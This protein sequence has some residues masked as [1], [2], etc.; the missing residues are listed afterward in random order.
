MRK[1]KWLLMG[2]IGP[3]LSRAWDG[4]KKESDSLFKKFSKDG[5]TQADFDALIQRIEWED[6]SEHQLEN[7][8]FKLLRS[9]LVGGEPS[10]AFDLLNHWINR[11]SEDS[12]S[13]TCQEVISKIQAVGLYL[14]Q[15][16]AHHEEWFS[17]IKPI[18]DESIKSVDQKA[19]ESDFYEGV[20]V[21]YRHILCG[22]DV[23]RTKKL[24]AI[25]E[26]YQDGKQVVVVHGASGQ[27][28]SALAYRYLH[29]YVPSDWRFSIGYVEDRK[30]AANIALAISDHHDAFEAPVYVYIDVR[31]SDMEWP[32]LIKLL[33]R[34][35]NI[36]VL[37]TIREEDLARASV[38][39][40][41]LGFPHFIDLVL[42]ESEA[43]LI[44]ENL[45]KR[46]ASH[47]YPSFAEAW[48]HFG[49]QGPLLE[50]VFL[51]TQTETL[52]ERVRNQVSRL[53]EEVRRGE[54]SPEELDLLRVCS[55]AT[56]Y[57]AQVA[58]KDVCQLIHLN[59]PSATLR[60]FEQEYLLRLSSDGHR[61]VNLHPLRSE[62]LAQEL[63]DE[64]F[65][66]WVDAAEVALKVI[67]D[68]CLEGFLLYAFSRHPEQAQQL[69]EK[70]LNSPPQSWVGLIG[71]ARTF[72]WLGIKDY[73][74]ENIH[75]I[76]DAQ[77]LFG[78]GWFMV[79]NFDLTGQID[80]AGGVDD[81]FK[82]VNPELAKMCQSLRDQQTPRDR[83]FLHLRRWLASCQS[84]AEPMI[85][86]DWRAL[87]ELTSWFQFLGVQNTPFIRFLANLNL[88]WPNT[89]LSLRHLCEL[90]NSLKQLSGSISKPLVEP[91]WEEVLER[92]K[93]ELLVI[94]L[95]SDE[96]NIKAHYVIDEELLS[97]QASEHSLH[98]G[99]ME[100]VELLALLFPEYETYGAQGYGH[101]TRLV[102]T[103]Y[104]PTRKDRIEAS[105]LRPMWLS[106]VNPTFLSLVEWDL[107]PMTWVEYA[108]NSLEIRTEI[109]S[110]LK[111]LE[112]ALIAYFKKRRT[113]NLG[114]RIDTQRWDNAQKMSQN[115][116]LLPQLA[117]D[118]WGLV[119]ETKTMA[120]NQNGAIGGQPT[121]VVA[122]MIIESYRKLVKPVSGYFSACQNFLS[123]AL[124]PILFNSLTARTTAPEQLE[125]LLAE[126]EK[127]NVTNKHSHL[128]AI[129]LADARKELASYQF[130]FRKTVGVINSKAKLESLELKESK[131][132]E[133]LCPLW[134]QFVYSPETTFKHPGAK[135]RIKFKNILS[136]LKG[137]IDAA[138]DSM[139]SNAYCKFI[140][141]EMMYQGEKALWVGLDVSEH[142]ELLEEPDLVRSLFGSAFSQVQF[143]S[144]EYH[145][146]SFLFEHVIVVPHIRNYTFSSNALCIPL[147][148]LV[149]KEE[150]EL[151]NALLYARELEA[152]TIKALG[153]DIITSP[154]LKFIESM[155]KS[156]GKLYIL[157]E[158]LACLS[159][160]PEDVGEDGL[161]IFKEYCSH[162][163]LKIQELIDG[164]G[165]IIESSNVVSYCEKKKN[166]DISDA[167]SFVC[168]VVQS[169]MPES[170]DENAFT[171]DQQGL[172][173]WAGELAESTAKIGIAQWYALRGEVDSNMR[174]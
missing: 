35:Q 40:Y 81:L 10:S 146:L 67:A 74:S 111:G 135:C 121:P 150:E 27:G 132:F 159:N 145:V 127:H 7:N 36:R 84:F 17:S 44:F 109:F 149:G 162:K 76:A 171:L 93:N 168:D 130:A 43:C 47:S 48:A 41:E 147:V 55:V 69:V 70:V 86:E 101:T 137:V 21:G 107:R 87:T 24:S 50:F 59:A 56:A 8:V 26:A 64:V 73:I 79:L 155:S 131:L 115:Y 57:E 90:I 53:N 172:Y 29:D 61:I 25:D 91:V 52:Q 39:Q 92:Y 122:S 163:N 32:E 148:T 3:E 136:E 133:S 6:L 71:V 94:N 140:E 166:P 108:Q 104:D 119:S 99:T 144:F 58:I 68:E 49:G 1:L 106:Q 89:H 142:M 16:A 164:F 2:P 160:I 12:L 51:L 72:L 77:R 167:V 134:Y 15:R 46:G 151:F 110:V 117:V 126:L 120:P 153:F 28:K 14:E 105:Q 54:L 116:P 124:D 128:S 161:R 13:L 85:S 156:I 66:S 42:I 37:V 45:V 100:R 170:D 102:P 5:Y 112:K 62:I 18:V 34:R 23:A 103:D 129:N 118:E 174:E 38:P 19:V 78:K 169:A 30:H 31:P 4:S 96:G 95:V 98:D 157:A 123:Q 75:L 141:S 33:V 125:A 20:S 63:C 83:V 82:D 113:D 154:A 158:H 173:D 65:H 152:G 88:R 80:L 11:A 143:N 165:P 114:N 139:G 97:S 138:F 22:L 9:T 60:L